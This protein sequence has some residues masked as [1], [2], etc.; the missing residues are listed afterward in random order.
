[1]S[2]SKEQQTSSSKDNITENKFRE[3][4]LLDF[5]CS[6]NAIVIKTVCYWPPERKMDQWNRIGSPENR[7]VLYGQLTF[8]K[9]IK[10][11][12]WRKKWSF[13]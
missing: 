3:L 10:A 11:I 1:M 12:Q 2:T 8:N 13:Q 4:T 5:K 9:S 6:Y 7:P